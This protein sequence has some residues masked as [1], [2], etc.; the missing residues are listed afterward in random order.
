[1][2]KFLLK[3]LINSLIKFYRNKFSSLIIILKKMKLRKIIYLTICIVKNIN[4][5]N[6]IT[7]N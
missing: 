6:D 3:K 7:I 4:I 1:M 2:D 5:N